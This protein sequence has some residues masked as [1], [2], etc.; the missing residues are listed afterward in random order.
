MTRPPVSRPALTSA[1]AA[2]LTILATAGCTTPDAGGN[3]PTTQAATASDVDNLDA[4][5]TSAP[6]LESPSSTPSADEKTGSTPDAE[7][8]AGTSALAQPPE[9]FNP[10]LDQ[11]FPVIDHFL[12]AWAAAYVL[13]D[14]QPLQ[15]VSAQGCALCSEVTSLAQSYA[16]EGSTSVGGDITA[17]SAKRTARTDTGARGWRMDLVMDPIAFDSPDGVNRVVGGFSNHV[18]IGLVWEDQ[19]WLVSE[20][21]SFGPVGTAGA[22]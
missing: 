5:P 10:D 21:T 4:T 19:R 16:A 1:L 2:L 6:A 14:T 3:R 18:F 11:T 17:T 8:A 22:E 7:G 15:D 9:M 13:G 12:H 20:V